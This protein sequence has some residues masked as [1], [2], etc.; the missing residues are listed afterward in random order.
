[1]FKDDAEALHE[2]VREALDRHEND[3]A[4][5]LLIDSLAISTKEGDIALAERTCNNLGIL[6]TRR[7]DT[8]EA[9]SYY[10]LSMDACEKL[11]LEVSRA[12]SMINVANILR[13]R[14]NPS[15]MDEAHRLYYAA[16]EIGRRYQDPKIEVHAWRGLGYISQGRLNEF[17]IS[18]DIALQ[19]NEPILIMES[20]FHLGRYHQSVGNTTKAEEYYRKYVRINAT[21][22]RPLLDFFTNHGY[23]DPDEYWDF[24]PKTSE[25]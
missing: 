8:D 5:K 25:T 16:Y 19:S 1:M 12:G 6:A 3:V 9:L 18:L 21:T 22:D 17:G 4:E 24:P 2:R 7:G 14:G 11:G 23:T 13:N 10:Q 20:F 15:D